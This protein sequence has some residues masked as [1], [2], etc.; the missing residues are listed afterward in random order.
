MLWLSTLLAAGVWGFVGVWTWVGVRAWRGM[1][2]LPYQP[3]RRVPWTSLDLAV[4][5]GLYIVILQIT[6]RL[7]E[8]WLDPELTRADPLYSVERAS[9]DHV[10]AKLLSQGDLWILLFCT[11]SAVVVAPV[12]EEFLFRVLL[13]GWLEAGHRRLEPSMPTLKRLVPRGV[14]PVVLAS[15]LF[16]IIHFHVERPMRDPRYEISLM[17]GTSAVS[18]LVMA[19]AVVLL[20]ER[21]GATG[22]D[23]GWVPGKFLHDVKL[24]LLAFA[25][26]AVPVYSVQYAFR[27]LLPRYV[28]PDPFPLFLLAL[29]LGTLYYRTHRIV[30]AITLHMSLNATSVAMAWLLMPS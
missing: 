6:R 4:I 16:A 24:G 18:L 15:L 22:E 29:G 26:L 20:R 3:R 1:P 11:L 7:I 25:G 12:V 21:V 10:I 17:L 19:L 27:L 9:S 28:A 14:G 23:L 5:V 30:P 13:Q 8:A 2:V